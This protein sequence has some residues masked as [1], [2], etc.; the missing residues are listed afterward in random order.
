MLVLLAIASLAA[1]DL[2][3]SDAEARLKMAMQIAR[4]RNSA[5]LVA[6]V[7]ALAR[8]FKSSLPADADAKLRELEAKVGIDPGGWSMAGQPLARITA[9]MSARSKALGGELSSAMKSGDPA[10]V[11]AVTRQMTEILGD[12]AGVP[13]GRR[14]GVK[15]EPARLA[16]AQAV[17]MFLDAIASQSRAVDE[18]SEGRPLPDQMLRLY[19]YVLE[20]TAIARPAVA[21]HA[22]QHLPQLDRL[23]AGTA[24]IL[25]D[26]QQ[27]AGHFPFPDLRGKNIRF[28][29]MIQRQL[30]AGAIT[31]DSGWVITPDPDGGS[32]FDTGVCG[33]ALILAG[34]V[35]EKPAWTAAGVRAADWAVAQH[36]CPNFNY[37]AFSVSLLSHA[38]GTTGD[39]KYLDAAMAKFRVGVAP[40]QAPN[41]RWIDAHNART[42]YHVILLRGIA[43]LAAALPKD[44]AADRA[45]VD[46]VLKPAVAALLTEFDAA[47]ITVEAMAELRILKAVMSDDRRLDDAA[48]RM[49]GM[50]IGKCTDG[51]RS[52]MGVSPNQLAAVVADV[53]GSR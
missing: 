25:L 32:Q 47:G 45:E 44:R 50:I 7:E 2:S 27:P 30:D 17:K 10:K 53:R 24:K 1:A 33:S 23:A 29:D 39:A 6:E 22:P 13:D 42:V 36:C 38:Y 51:R 12:Q 52:R 16:E 34:K 49:A 3:P 18:L 43:D 31:I 20:A 35:F 9:E 21:Q 15:A 46:R 8:S 4:E 48:D 28:G 14:V 26:R 40:G 37:N 5:P 11:L 41:G 19:A